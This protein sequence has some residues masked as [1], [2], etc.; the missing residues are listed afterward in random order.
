MNIFHRIDG[1]MDR[2]C[3]C[4]LLLCAESP[5]CVV[6]RTL[7]GRLPQSTSNK[8]DTRK[9]KKSLLCNQTN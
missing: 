5:W 3:V 4:V 9:R 7:V 8:K 1:W 6:G 2:V